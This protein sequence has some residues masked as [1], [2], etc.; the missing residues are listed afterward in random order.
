MSYIHHKIV[1]FCELLMV[2]S[3]SQEKHV[4]DFVLI[5]LQHSE[6]FL[7][8]P[9]SSEAA[10]LLVHLKSESSCRFL[11][12]GRF[13]TTCPPHHYQDGDGTHCLSPHSNACQW[14]LYVYQ[15]SVCIGMFGPTSQSN[16]G[17]HHRH[18]Q[19]QTRVKAS[20]SKAF[21]LLKL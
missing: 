9:Y 1:V 14:T 18:R 12:G 7:N 8:Q 10:Y 15:P 21:H 11:Q 2:L 19:Y 5:P 16:C 17:I 6:Y 13:P 4:K 20:L 3:I